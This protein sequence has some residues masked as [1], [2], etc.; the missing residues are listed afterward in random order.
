MVVSDRPDH[1]ADVL[2]NDPD[3]ILRLADAQ[4]GGECVDQRATS[5]DSPARDADLL[6]ELDGITADAYEVDM[7]SVDG[8][9]TTS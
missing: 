4:C 2:L 7:T 8:A 3:V 6:D 9:P 5:R 1:L